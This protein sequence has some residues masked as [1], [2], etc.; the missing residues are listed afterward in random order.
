MNKI[1]NNEQCPIQKLKKIQVT[2]QSATS[3]IYKDR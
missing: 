1:E 3:K 2:P